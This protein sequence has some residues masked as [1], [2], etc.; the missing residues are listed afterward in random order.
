MFIPIEVLLEILDKID[1]YDDILRFC[2]ISSDLISICRSESF[3]KRKFNDLHIEQYEEEGRKAYN[4][5]QRYRMA[6]FIRRVK[7]YQDD[8]WLARY[9]HE[10]VEILHDMF[11][12]IR[13]H[14]AILNIPLFAGFREAV[15][16]KISSLIDIEGAHQLEKFRNIV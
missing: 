4:Y 12:F 15:K 9:K 16:E 11:D 5:R 3:W 13:K 7:K 1:D 10:Q 14:R 8:F 2:S 6:W